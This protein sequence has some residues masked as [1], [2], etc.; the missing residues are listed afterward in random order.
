MIRVRNW[1]KF[2]HYKKRRPPWI[3]LYLRLIDEDEDDSNWLALTDSERG[4][5]ASIWL[6]AAVRGDRL[7]KD[8]PEWIARRIE[9]SG[10]I[11]L[12]RFVELGWLERDA[13]KVA[14]NVASNVALDLLSPERERERETEGETDLCADDGAAPTPSRRRQR[15][16]L[17]KGFPADE[18]AN[19]FKLGAKVTAGAAWTESARR[20]VREY[21]GTDTP[22][23]VED[24]EIVAA[25]ARVAWGASTIKMQ[26]LLRWAKTNGTNWGDNVVNARAWDADGRPA[27]RA[28]DNGLSPEDQKR[29]DD[30]FGDYA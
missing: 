22:V 14:S 28:S 16:P 13:S 12:N 6:L 10:P 8:D 1:R 11:N 24:M 9:S 3:K 7:L 20:G 2:Q 27:K 18:V 5:L 30:G 17:P 19:A 26:N 15:H 4:Q 25:F 21:A 29:I 23:T